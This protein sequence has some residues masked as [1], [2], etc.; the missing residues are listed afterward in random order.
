MNNID[1]I[2]S[3]IYTTLALLLFITPLVYLSSLRDP[4]SLPRYALISIISGVLLILVSFA[5]YKSKKLYISPV[6]IYIFS[7]FI[8]ALLSFTWSNDPKNTLI[9]VIQLS[10]FIII[11]Y[12]TIYIYATKVSYFPVVASVIA[13]VIASS[14]GI[15]QYFNFNPFNYFQFMI[16]ASTFTNTNFASVYLD[17]IVP[18]AFVLIFAAKTNSQRLVASISAGIC[19]SFILISHTRGSW[20]GLLISAFVFTF[21]IYKH[22]NVRKLFFLNISKKLPYLLIPF[23]IAFTLFF[24]PP[25][26]ELT[27]PVKDSQ[28]VLGGSAKIRLNAYINS[29]AIIKDYPIT[30]TGYGGF[31][32]S[33]RNY[34][35]SIVPFTAINEHNSLSRLHNDP[36]QMFVELGLPGGLLFLLIYLYTAKN[37]WN[38]LSSHKDPKIIFISTG[39]FLALTASGVHSF[40]DFPFHKPTSALQI[41]CWLGLLFGISAK[42][43]TLETSKA[44]ILFIFI[45]IITLLFSAYNIFFYKNYLT[46]SEYRL[47]ASEALNAN[48]CQRAKYYSNK[49]IETFD[50][51][52]LHLSLYSHIYSHCPFS[53]SD[54]MHAMH[55]VLLQD[56]TNIRALIT[57]GEIF[58][59]EQQIKKAHENFLKITQILPHKSSGYIG[60][61]Y[62]EINLQ[63]YNKALKLLAHASKLEPENKNL[64]ELISNVR[65]NIRKPIGQN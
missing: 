32:S 21:L 41:W 63:N 48:N 27:K 65:K 42:Q 31:R 14:I 40:F 5:A 8:L 16:P 7:F 47:Q 1:K 56:P 52:F 49:M 18:V 10:S 11:C 30:G 62:V 23:V 25:S 39:V 61:A 55:R 37:S 20:L 35:F 45:T 58:Y 15:A 26:S 6:I 28:L 64:Q 57:Q 22:K 3:L 19:L 38:I 12:V 53:R 9:E 46:A 36:L 33:F 24:I 60:L 13:G 59:Q 51:D 54:K 50:K 29:M 43:I 34:M 4:S 2:N 44:K 17:L